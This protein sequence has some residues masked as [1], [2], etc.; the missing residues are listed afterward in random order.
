[1]NLVYDYYAAKNTFTDVN[2]KNRKINLIIKDDGYDAARTIPLVDELIDSQKVFAMWTL[3]SPNTMKTFDK[4]NQRCIPQPL[5]MTG[6]PAWGDPV[7]HPWTTGWQLAYNT[8]AVLWG[9]F[10]E[11]HMSEFPSGKVT[12]AGLVMNNDFGKSYDGGFKA[13]LAQSPIKDKI[14]YATETIEA[15]AP[16]VTDPMTTLAAK[17]PDYFIAMIAGTPCTQAI[18]EAAQ[19][20]MKEKVKYLFQPSVCYS[21]SFV[22]KDKVGGDGSASNGWWVV[23]G[24]AKDINDA[25]QFSDPAVAWARDLLISHGID[26]KSSGSLGSGFLFALP[27]VQLLQIADQLNGGLTR[28]NLIV[29]LRAYDVTHPLLLKGMKNNMNGNSDAYFVEGGIYQKYNSAKQGWDSQGRVIDLSGKSK[30][31]AWDQGAGL[32]K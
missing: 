14:T 25:A 4:L 19:N 9:A 32:C 16:T 24:G 27:M 21:S 18:T 26:P 13:Y 30:N 1:M 29:A 20:G 23:N 2:G 28:T 22:G 10:I 15:A 8:E 6:H 31:C 11:Q 3:G 12:V 17:N 5:S 7:N